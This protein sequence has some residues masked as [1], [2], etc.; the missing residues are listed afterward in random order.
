[1]IHIT[2]VTKALTLTLETCVEA[3]TGLNV[4]RSPLGY[5]APRTTCIAVLTEETTHVTTRVMVHITSVAK[6]LAVTLEACVE[7]TTGL[8]VH[9]RI[10]SYCTSRSTCIAILTEEATNVITRLVVHLARV[11]EALALTL[12]A[13][14]SHGCLAH[15]WTT[16]HSCSARSASIAIFA[17]EA[18]HISVMVHIAGVT[19]TLA[20]TFET[21]IEATTRLNRKS[22][23]YRAPR[24]TSVTILAEEATFMRILIMVHIAGVAKTLAFTLEARL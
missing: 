4:Q 5:Y 20:L 8:N 2:R 15:R 12:E 16:F 1:M 19:K 9:K 24:P 6:A 11:T 7:A 13:G 3:T 22:L 17:K 23:G 10:L 14:L 18:P 21:L